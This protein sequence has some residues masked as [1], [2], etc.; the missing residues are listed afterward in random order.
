MKK[1]KEEVK[2]YQK[3]YYAK[4]RERLRKAG[5]KR[6]KEYMSK[7][8]NRVKRRHYARAYRVK[9]LEKMRAYDREYVKIPKQKERR[10][11]TLK[12]WRKKNPKKP[13]LYSLKYYLKNR[14]KVDLIHK[15]WR[16]KKVK[17]VGCSLYKHYNK[18]TNKVS[19]ALSR[20]FGCKST[21][22]NQQTKTIKSDI[23]ILQREIIKLRSKL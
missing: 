6:F 14:E 21:L 8:E 7:P 18:K 16:D 11:K 5:D 3:E 17:E 4:N 22:K 12:E 13:S 1:T 20:A 10:K 9:N 15:Q 2:A 23:Q 19:G